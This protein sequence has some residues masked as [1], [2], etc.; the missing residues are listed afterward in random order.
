M[1]GNEGSYIH[2][3][4]RILQE[5]LST[6]G[7]GRFS[8]IF[9]EVNKDLNIQFSMTDEGVLMRQTLTISVSN[10][11]TL[12]RDDHKTYKDLGTI[13][14]DF[15]IARNDEDS[16]DFSKPVLINITPALSDKDPVL[17]ARFD[18]KQQ[19][20]DRNIARIESMHLNAKANRDAGVH[21]AEA[22][23]LFR[24]QV[25][26]KADQ[27]HLFQLIDLRQLAL[28]RNLNAV[29]F[30]DQ[31]LRYLSTCEECATI[32]DCS[33]TNVFLNQ[34]KFK[35]DITNTS[36]SSADLEGA[37]F[38]D[39]TLNKVNFRDAKNIDKAT[40]DYCTLNEVDFRDAKNIDKATFNNCTFINCQFDVGVEV[41]LGIQQE[42]QKPRRL[43]AKVFMAKGAD[44]AV[45]VSSKLEK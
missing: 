30:K 7:D 28:D 34:A 17:Y 14:A 13:T 43:T 27:D 36:F 26:I 40:F 35:R 37:T 25:F 4:S 6:E 11:I 39:C 9:P 22:Q 15:L 10:H 8:I 12:N 5:Y 44:T 29:H 42:R 45:Q 38:D 19:E 1:H 41:S 18:Q 31:N 23:R 33:F 24:K 2:L 32:T 21:V 3:F 16:F 20:L